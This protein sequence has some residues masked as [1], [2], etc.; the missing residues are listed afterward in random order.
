MLFWVARGLARLG[1]DITVLNHCGA[2]S[3]IFEGVRYL[4]LA[5]DWTKWQA[6]VRGRKADVLVLYRRMLDVLTDIPS[7]ARV[8]WALDHQGVYVSDPPGLT[9][10]LAIFWRQSSGPL[11]HDRVDRVIVISKFMADLFHWLFRTPQEKLVV[12]PVGIDASLVQGPPPQR[13][14]MR[15][16]YSSVPERGLGQL[17][18]EIIPEIQR[19]HPDAE[20]DV[21]SYQP[22]DEYKQPVN[23]GIHF[24]GWVKKEDL[25]RALGESLLMLYPGNFE[26]MG[27]IS[28]LESM[29]A[30]TPAV[31][32]TLG[33]L[34]ELAGEGTRGL[35]VEGRPGTLEFARRFVEV[36]LELLDDPDRL[37]RMRQAAREYAL[38]NHAWESVVQR[39]DLELRKLTGE[40]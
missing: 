34:A 12:V 31:T 35:A 3:G 13:A 28:V 4:D 26:E 15:F 32:S 33:V 37:A 21:F 17:L 38:T 7:K 1:H 8:F 39:W 16:V 25:I 29:A 22:L 27:A 10:S 19:V 5:R 20:L 9:R 14:G 11:F 40:A 6:E 24:R 2:D 23:G 18:R 36:T 30:G